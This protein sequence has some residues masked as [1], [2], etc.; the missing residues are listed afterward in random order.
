MSIQIK[1]VLVRVPIGGNPKYSRLLQCM[2]LEFLGLHKSMAKFKFVAL[3]DLLPNSMQELLLG[4]HALSFVLVREFQT[5]I[6]RYLAF[7][8]YY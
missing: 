4:S 5:L 8:F 6:Q 2:V 7:E 3:V 1:S